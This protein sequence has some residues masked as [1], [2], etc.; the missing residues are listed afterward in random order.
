MEEPEQTQAR[1]EGLDSDGR[2][3]FIKWLEFFK[4]T[5]AEAQSAGDPAT[6]RALCN[7]ALIHAVELLQPLLAGPG[8]V[9]REQPQRSHGQLFSMVRTCLLLAADC[10][11]AGV[12]QGSLPCAV[13]YADTISIMG[14]AGS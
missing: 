10:A 5:R 13:Y 4:R 2:Q 3:H 7:A 12:E 6:L 8:G 14:P 11:W 9:Q 1:S